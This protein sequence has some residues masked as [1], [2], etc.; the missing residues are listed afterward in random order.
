[1][2]DTSMSDKTAPD[3]VFVGHNIY[4]T[5]FVIDRLPG[6]YRLSIGD[7]F[8]SQEVRRAPDIEALLRE[9]NK[10]GQKGGAH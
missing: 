7:L 9:A 1:M 3:V 6:A 5:L 2:P 10:I 8:A 4:C